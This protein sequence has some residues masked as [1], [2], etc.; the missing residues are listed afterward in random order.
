MKR[1]NLGTTDVSAIGLGCMGMA[2]VAGMGA[3]Y[4]EVDKDEAV[5]TIHRA[6]EIGIDFL[7]TAEVY[8]PYANETLLGEAL[9]GKRDKVFIAT[10][11]GFRIADGRV[12]G[13]DSRPDNIRAV[14]EASLKRL[15][16]DVIDLFYQHRV[17]PDVPI[18]DVVGTLADLQAQGKIR[19]IGL[20]EAGV[21]TLER[22]AATHRIDAL[23]SEYSLWEREVEN[24]ILPVCRKHG[25]AFV[26]Y[27]P[28]GR[29]FLTGDVKRAED[30]PEGDYRR[31]DPRYQGAN[32]DANMELVATV[33][34]IADAHGATP[35]QVALAWLLAQGPDII[36]IPGTKKVKRLEE[37]AAAADLALTAADADALD[38]AAPVGGTAGERY[39]TPAKLAMLRI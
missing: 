22:A 29:G 31:N 30:Y 33:K 11:F 35:A 17:D 8:G 28:L 19:F 2:G 37:N 15:Q 38:A 32:F 3:M 1:R 6:I 21:G 10:K 36:P 24:D 12:K 27:S 9:K 26:P 23:Q 16:T 14:C 7:D 25:I 5:R 20:S 18:E 34:R 4:G 39:D 13:T